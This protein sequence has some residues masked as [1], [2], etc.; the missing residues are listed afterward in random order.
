LNDRTVHANL[1]PIT[2]STATIAGV[3]AIFRDISP[4]VGGWRAR[5]EALTAISQK[6]RSPM[7]AIA[8]YSDLLLSDAAGVTDPMQR[9]YLQRIR[10]GVQR[11]E[12][13]LR[14]LSDEAA[15]AG[16]S[17]ETSTQSVSDVINEA[18]DTAQ[19]ALFL[20]GVNIARDIPEN[21]PPVQFGAQYVSRILADL[22]AAAGKRT[23][24]GHSV[25]VD[26]QVQWADGWPTYLVVLIQDGGALPEGIPPLDEDTAVRAARS[27]AEEEG[28][29]IWVEPKA[30][31]GNLLSFL[32]PVAEVAS[33]GQVS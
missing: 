11:I 6:L 15:A 25:N 1:I 22:L 14:E 24:V 18:I 9:R 5:D 20:D 28:G 3:V 7:T 21:L 23:A 19:D 31:G 2:N 8:S 10:H 4:K 27:L 17:L 16:Q 12:T 33:P 32:L 13:I 29:R 26:A 30:E